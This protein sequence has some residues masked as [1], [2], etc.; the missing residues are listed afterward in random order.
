MIFGEKYLFPCDGNGNFG[1][2]KIEF[3]LKT[4]LLFFLLHVTNERDQ[5]TYSLYMK[6]KFEFEIGFILFD[7]E[8]EKEI[9]VSI[10]FF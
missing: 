10:A 8:N 9:I 2:L 5:K 1:W 6:E 4:F 7:S 3:S